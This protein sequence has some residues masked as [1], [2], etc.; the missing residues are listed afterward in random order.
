MGY[1]TESVMG[2]DIFYTEGFWGEGNVTFTQPIIQSGN[3]N[4]YLQVDGGITTGSRPSQFGLDPL[5]IEQDPTRAMINS[6][7]NGW[8][9]IGG[10]F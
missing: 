9:K 2:R 10:Q 8:I 5:T 3:R 7:Y 6:G 1:T 4:L